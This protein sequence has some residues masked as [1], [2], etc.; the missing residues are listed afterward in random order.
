MGIY[1]PNDHWRILL[2]I[3]GEFTKEEDYLLTRAGLEYGYQLPKEW[4]TFGNFSY[5]I[6]WNAY[7]NWGIGLGIAKNFRGK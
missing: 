2:G 5:D 4:K 3:G 7:D 6:K 1:K